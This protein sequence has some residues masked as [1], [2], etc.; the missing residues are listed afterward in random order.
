MSFSDAVMEI[1]AG[2]E[3][4]WVDPKRFAEMFL[5]G[6]A[7]SMFHTYDLAFRKLWFH[8]LEIGKSV[9]WWTPM[10]LA[11]YLVLLD[12]CNNTVNMVKQASAVVTLLKEA[13]ELESLASSRIVQTVKK[14]VMKSARERDIVRRK[15]VKSVMLLDH[16]RLLICKLFK[17]PAEKVK[18][19]DQRFL[20]MMLLLFFA[21]KRFVCD[22][23]VLRGGHLEFYV[24]SSKTDQLG[25]GF[26]FHV[27]GEKFE[28]FSIPKVLN[29]YLE[30][31]GLRGTDYLF[32][33]FRNEKGKVVAQG[34]YYI[35]YSSSAVQLKTFCLKNG[36]LPLTM[37]SGRRG[38]ATAAVEVGIDRM[39]IQ[40]VGNWSSV[41]VD[42]YFCP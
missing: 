38:G 27:T 22:I 20:V 29:W 39:N 8:G 41:C 9:F 3:I 21:M 36:I 37:H 40:A 31:T 25:K 35:S 30:S 2:Q 4:G 18:P 5:A 1:R 15:K 11:G 28:G 13:V 6:R 12:E 10:D 19:V 33:R 32:S 14:G 34:S 23:N 26:V 42:S 16:M 7:K 17:R 24:Y